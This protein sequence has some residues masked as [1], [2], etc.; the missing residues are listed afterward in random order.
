MSKEIELAQRIRSL[1]ASKGFTVGTIAQREKVLRVAKTLKD[2]GI[3]EFDVVTKK[4][5][6]NV[7]KVAAI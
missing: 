3:I 6:G 7:F 2:A 1:R 5:S 4:R